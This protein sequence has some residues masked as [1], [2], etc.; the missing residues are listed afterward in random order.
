MTQKTSALLCVIGL[1]ITAATAL[2][3]IDH[4]AVFTN[5]VEKMARTSVSA[6]AKGKLEVPVRV[7][8]SGDSRAEAV[9]EAVIFAKT[10]R[11][12]RATPGWA[13]SFAR[14]ALRPARSLSMLR[15]STGSLRSR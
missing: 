4:N 2:L 6:L 7:E 15:L 13:A 5:T 1:V 8:Y 9:V 12:P 14:R 10:A 3:P 11:A